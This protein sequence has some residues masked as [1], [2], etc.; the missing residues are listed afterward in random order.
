MAHITS[1]ACKNAT[2]FESV[3]SEL[4]SNYFTLSMSV[5]PRQN[6]VTLVSEMDA[7]MLSTSLRGLRY[8][9]DNLTITSLD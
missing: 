7:D 6:S 2:I 1:I 9:M 5:L 4:C 8:N 3:V